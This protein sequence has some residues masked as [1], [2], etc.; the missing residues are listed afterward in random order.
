[1]NFVFEK[2]TNGFFLRDTD[3]E[4]EK[5]TLSLQKF[6]IKVLIFLKDIVFRRAINFR[7][8]I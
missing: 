4:K 6:R 3:L 5:I 8:I 7:I 2:I 1:M